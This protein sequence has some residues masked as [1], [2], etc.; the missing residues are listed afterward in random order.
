MNRISTMLFCLGL[1]VAQVGYAAESRK[2]LVLRDGWA[3]ES[4]ARD[5]QRCEHPARFDL[6]NQ[7]KKPGEPY[8]RQNCQNDYPPAHFCAAFRWL[9]DQP[10]SGK[11][12]GKSKQLRSSRQPDDQYREERG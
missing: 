10:D 8:A 9:S 11:R 7:D 4:S 1:V 2:T 3:I 6:S 5:N 12:Q